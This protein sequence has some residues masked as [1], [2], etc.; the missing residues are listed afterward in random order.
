[1]PPG[2]I[3]QNQE[4][5]SKVFLQ[6]HHPTQEVENGIKQSAYKV[7][8]G[9]TWKQFEFALS[10]ARL[11]IMEYQAAKDDRNSSIVCSQDEE[12]R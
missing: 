10:T 5:D 6:E 12:A 3:Y 7:S 9:Q 4:L 2:T 8:M 11:C 1:M